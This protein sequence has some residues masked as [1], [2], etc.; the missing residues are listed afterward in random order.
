MRQQGNQKKKSHRKL[1]VILGIAAVVLVILIILAVRGLKNMTEQIASAM[2]SNTVQAEVGEI[3]VTT[4]GT[5]VVEAARTENVYADYS[6]TLKKLYKQNGEKA[7][8]GEVIAEFESIALNDTIT[9]LETQLNQVDSLLASAS[10]DGATAVKAPVYGR[11]KQIFAAEG[12]SVLTVQ[13]RQEA[14]AVISADGMLKVEFDTESSTEA[15]QKVQILYGDQVLDGRIL[16]VSGNHTTAVFEDGAD[17]QLNQEVTVQAEDGTKLGTGLTDCGHG[18]YV[19]ADCGV[20][21]SLSVAENTEVSAGETLFELDEVSCSAE[22]LAL[23]EQR[24]QLAED[25]KAAREYRNGYVLTAETDCI[26]S[27]LTAKE[28][29]T[30]PAGSVVCRLMDTGAYQVVLAIDE[31]DIRGIEAG[32]SVEVTVD[33]IEDTVYEGTVSGVSMAGE[34]TNGVGT[35][36]VSVLLAE[37]SDLLPGMS[38]NGRITMDYKTD[39][40][41]VPVDT[42]KTIDGKRTVTVVKEDG[43]TENREV[44]VGLVNNQYAEILS[45]VEEGEHLQVIVRLEDLY[46]QLGITVEST[47]E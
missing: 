31:L 37:A 30:L 39:A 1:F 34:N 47:A 10:R 36:R 38:A 8:A 3:A 41:L 19:T 20:I 9:S 24:E 40:L 25:L 43:T 12:D 5:G 23:L 21:K 26:I 4:E 44:T 29:G 45:G 2:E 17:Y 16:E 28:G 42:L 7:A 13:S 32:Q 33:A 46:S 35:Y 15:G 27:E 6:V 14:L 18:V 11:V 22:Y